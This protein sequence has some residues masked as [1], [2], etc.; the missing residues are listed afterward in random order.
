MELLFQ[1]E[2]DNAITVQECL[3][4]IKK[5]SNNKVHTYAA[6]RTDA[7]VRAS[8]QVVHFDVVCYPW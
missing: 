1:D 2:Q 5:I 6:G 7:G 8:G 3:E 4:K